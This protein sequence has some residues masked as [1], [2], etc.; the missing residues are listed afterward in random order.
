MSDLERL[1][2]RKL[3]R[4]TGVI[5]F[6]IDATGCNYIRKKIMPETETRKR[7]GGNTCPVL[8]P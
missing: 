7:A 4:M 8:S 2:K 1:K 5:W 3:P 6:A